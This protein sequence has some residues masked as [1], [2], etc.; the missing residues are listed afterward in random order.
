VEIGPG[1]DLADLVAGERLA[2]A[3]V[4][5]VPAGRYARAALVHLGLWD[6]VKDRLAEAENVR[7]ALLLVARGEAPY[8]IVYATDA[9]EAG[10]SV[11]GGFPAE[12]HPPIVYPA[13][14]TASA[15]PAAAKFLA[16]LGSDAARAV[17]E[18]H[19]FTV[20]D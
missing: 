10:V 6:A 19:G 14:L 8:G 13:A 20:L 1:L 17:F 7:A 4:E 11:V 15:D 12:S 16:F 3:E 18:E 2:V 5:A 9:A